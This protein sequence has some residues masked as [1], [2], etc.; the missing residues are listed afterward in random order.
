[1]QSFT[2][3]SRHIVDEDDIKLTS[4]GVD[5][6]SSTS[7]LVFSRLEMRQQGQRYVVTRREILSESEILLTPYRDDLTIDVDALGSFIARQYDA[8]R[9]K[10]R[11]DRH[12]R[13]DFDR[14][15]RSGAATRARSPS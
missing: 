14:R 11:G 10:A 12:R 3:A 1:M 7:H 6:G 8:R 5:I 13:A 15:R 2:N 9:L 4:V